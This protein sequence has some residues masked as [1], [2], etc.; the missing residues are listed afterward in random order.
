MKKTIVAVLV[1][2]VEAFAFHSAT[3]SLVVWAATA[4]VLWRRAVVLHERTHLVLSACSALLGAF[5]SLALALLAWRGHTVLTFPL[6][7]QLY[8][9]L[10]LAAILGLL[11]VDT[12]TKPFEWREVGEASAD[13][14]ADGSVW[15]LLTSRTVPDLRNPTSATERLGA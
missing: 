15:D 10:A 1:F 14:W 3:A 9:A 5:G 8:S 11:L 2:L 7:W 4:M 13:A 12:R 6:R